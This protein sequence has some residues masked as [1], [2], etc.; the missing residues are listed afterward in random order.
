MPCLRINLEHVYRTVCVS[1]L[2]LSLSF[3]KLLCHCMLQSPGTVACLSSCMTT[4]QEFCGAKTKT[5]GTCDADNN[6]VDS[7]CSDANTGSRSRIPPPSDTNGVMAALLGLSPQHAKRWFQTVWR[8]AGVEH[9]PWDSLLRATL[10]D[11]DPLISKG[12]LTAEAVQFTTLMSLLKNFNGR[13]SLRYLFEG[14]YDMHISDKIEIVKSS[15]NCHTITAFIV[16][17][18]NQCIEAFLVGS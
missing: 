7:A 16:S 5:E 17:P 6:G 1:S 14:Q 4:V 11:T 8:S 13:E 15:C 10:D 12:F 3:P 2:S 18:L 9:R